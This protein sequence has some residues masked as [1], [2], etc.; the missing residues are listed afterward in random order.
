LE[1][2]WSTFVL[3]II[4]FLVLVWILKRFFYKPVLEVIARRRAGI[5]QTLAEA[6]QLRTDAEALQNQ[7]PQRLAD[8]E[9]ERQR[10]RE[11]LADEIEA[12]RTR[13]L[14]TLQS[15][16]EQEQ[17]KA[18]VAEARRQADAVHKAEETALMQAAGFAS[19]LLG[20]L[21]GPEL[22]Q[23]LLDLMLEQLSR[24]SDERIAA[25]RNNC[26]RAAETITVSSAWPLSETQR[27][28]LRQALA[29]TMGSSLPLRFEQD[30]ALLAGLRISIGAW[31]L[32]AN[33]QDELKSLA[34]FAHDAHYP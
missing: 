10:A 20:Q 21:A 13:R 26:G 27:E 7:Y 11:Q 32:S 9:Q 25:L 8:W 28:Q 15:Q 12:E 30:S 19:R 6:R 22:E 33:L 31:Q 18:R 3:E 1:L 5:E 34:E 2:N 14:A 16:L 17:E 24:L 23:R 4:N 29:A